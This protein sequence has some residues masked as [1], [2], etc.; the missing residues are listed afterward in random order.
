MTHGIRSAAEAHAAGR[1][2]TP[3]LMRTL[4][5]QDWLLPLDES[6]DGSLEMRSV[7][8]GATEWIQVYSDADQHML[9]L[10]SGEAGPVK[11]V[12]GWAAFARTLANPFVAVEIDPASPEPLQ[13]D[14]QL[15]EPLRAEVRHARLEYVLAQL[16][17]REPPPA[18][19]LAEL[20]VADFGLLHRGGAALLCPDEPEALM[21][22]YTRP[23]AAEPHLVAHPELE[24]ATLDGEALFGQA[25]ADLAGFVINPGSELAYLVTP[26][27]AQLIRTR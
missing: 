15:L 17:D 14:G 10:L 20:A 12:P 5:A 2:T 9:H 21:A 24:W 13:L 22:V 3:V 8:R 26:E 27:L 4:V 19:G 6:D 23:E 7:R 18:E 16:V 11:T 1:L 25:P